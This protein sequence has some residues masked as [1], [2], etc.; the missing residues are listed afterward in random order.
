M[1]G[2]GQKRKNMGREG[3]GLK[4]KNHGIKAVKSTKVS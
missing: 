3:A 4:M 2:E 1:G